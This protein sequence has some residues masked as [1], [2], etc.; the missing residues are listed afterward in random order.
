MKTNTFPV[1]GMSCAACA[2]SVESILK[3]T[4]G[5]KQ[6]SVNFAT[7]SVL[8]EYDAIEEEELQKVLQLVGYDLLL[9]EFHAEEEQ[10]KLRKAYYEDLQKRLIASTILTLPIFVFGIFF[11]GWEAG[12]WMSFCLSIPVLF[13]FGRSFYIGAYNQASNGYANMDTLVALSTGVAFLFSAFNTFFPG[14]WLSKGLQ[15]YVYFEAATVIIT[16]IT[17]GRWLEER[18]KYST[19]TAIKK[20]MGLQPQEVFLMDENGQ[21]TN[22][23]LNEVK[24]GDLLSVKPGGMLPVD[25][26]V[27]DGASFVDESSITGEPIPVEKKTGDQV[28]SGTTNQTGQFVLEAQKVGSETLLSKIIQTVKEAQGSK[29]PVQR[30]VD[31]IAAVFVPTV[32]LI[33]IL[34]FSLW[35]FLGSEDVFSHALI[36]SISVLVIACPCALG[37]ATPTALMVGLGRGAENQILIKD[38]VSLETAHKIDTVI[39]D[40]TGTVTVGE[41]VLTGYFGFEKADHLLTFVL[42]I[43]KKSEH[44]VAHALVRG[45]EEKEIIASEV[46]QFKSETGKGVAASCEYGLLR[47]GSQRYLNENNVLIPEHIHLWVKENERGGASFVFAGLDENCQ[48]VFKISDELKSTSREAIM[49]LQKMGI[50]VVMLSGD[51]QHTVEYVA[52]EVGIKKYKGG[53]M[54]S[55]KADYIR[56]LKK[57]AKTVAMVGDGVNDSEALALADISIAMGK[58][59]DIAMDVAQITLTHSD[60]TSIPKALKLSKKTVGGIKQN[61]FWAFIYNVLGIPIAAGVLYP[62]IGFTLDPMIAGAAMAFSSVS[63]V[64]NSLRLKWVKL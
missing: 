57:D 58:G 44:P 23:P 37:L 47:L 51:Q 14:F 13:Y 20:L 64:A 31:K 8:V 26:I 35:Y 4:N 48:G 15:P 3:N 62:F 25:G 7:H 1:T 11:M 60:L 24:V 18:V 29:A 45:L 54:P 42:G 28:F 6:A 43:E 33:S 46:K 22:I 10:E 52:R 36:N 19:G 16:F 9:D 34:T 63:V 55:E 38:A 39:L 17:F 49:D 27:K 2:S 21:E 59:S 56:T 61:L 32:V 12:K 50:D 30:L 5:V 41:P 40:K 53:C